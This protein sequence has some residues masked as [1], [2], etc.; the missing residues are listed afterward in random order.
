MEEKVILQTGTDLVS[1]MPIPQLNPCIRMETDS[2]WRTNIDGFP[3]GNIEKLR[4][5]EEFLNS[6][7]SGQDIA[8]QAISQMIWEGELGL[9]PD[10]PKGSAILVGPTG[11][12]K[13]ELVR[14]IAKYLYPET[15]NHSLTIYDMANYAHANSLL[16]LIGSHETDSGQWGRDLDNMG[17]RPGILLFDEL[18][19]CHP[20]LM[21]VFLAMLDHA[22]LTCSDGR[23][24]DLHKH[25]LFFTSNLASAELAYMQRL[26]WQSLQRKVF[27]SMEQH[28]TPE[29]C[30][31]FDLRQVMSPLTPT[32]LKQIT[33]QNLTT[34]L[35]RIQEALKI[36]IEMTS[37]DEI[38]SFLY[39]QV[40]WQYHQQKLGARLVRQT[41]EKHLNEALVTYFKKHNPITGQTLWLAVDNEQL[42]LQP[43]PHQNSKRTDHMLS[44]I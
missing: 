41:V 14:L 23:A 15:K 18:E 5:L 1:D 8:C 3:C 32:A 2:Q 42:I 11:V 28:F 4:G 35:H 21:P 9:R 25:Y 24:R 19:K 7:L 39:G 26:P 37:P 38:Q 30:A 20:S 13:T 6:H 31:R 16:Q 40:T 43:Q 34:H 12:G 44:L 17:E 29:F 36:H 33:V 10:T 22:R 27:Q